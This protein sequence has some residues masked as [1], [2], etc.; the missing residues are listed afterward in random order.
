MYISTISTVSLNVR[1]TSYKHE[2]SMRKSHLL[3]NSSI[4]C[5]SDDIIVDS[6]VS[7]SSFYNDN[8]GV[9]YKIDCSMSTCTIVHH[10]H[11]IM[12]IMMTIVNHIMLFF[13]I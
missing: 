3:R 5:L 12:I 8:H 13:V 11:I 4:I 2:T 10:N 1:A 7:T 9:W 6:I